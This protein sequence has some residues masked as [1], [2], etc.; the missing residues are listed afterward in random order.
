MRHAE[1]LKVI[2][3]EKCA[4]MDVDCEM[5]QAKLRCCGLCVFGVPLILSPACLLAEFVETVLITFEHES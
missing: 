5:K 2:G 3:S 1:G 4:E